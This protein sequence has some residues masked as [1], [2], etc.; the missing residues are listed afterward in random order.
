MKTCTICNQ[1]FSEVAFY[2]RIS[3]GKPYTMP[4]CKVCHHKRSIKWRQKNMEKARENVRKSHK[5]RKSEDPDRY[6]K[7]GE[8]SYQKRRKALDAIKN[9]PCTDCGE[10]FPPEC[11]DF[12]HIAENKSFGVGQSWTKPWDVV[13]DE[14]KKCEIVCSNCH[15]T[16]TRVRK[17]HLKTNRLSGHKVDTD[18]C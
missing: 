12:D 17:S 2:T 8:A 14:I 1:V 6:R 10:R 18:S 9:V 3:R 7:Y 4:V 13:L 11:M 5:K 15:R 16:R